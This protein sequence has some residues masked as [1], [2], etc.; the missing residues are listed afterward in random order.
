MF[1]F[2]LPPSLS[3]PDLVAPCFCFCFVFP[4]SISQPL[5][6]GFQTHPCTS[7]DLLILNPV[8]TTSALSLKD[9][10][11]WQISRTHLLCA[12]HSA[13]FWGTCVLGTVLCSYKPV[14]P[15]LEASLVP[16]SLPSVF[17]Q[18]PD[19]CLFYT[20]LLR[21]VQQL[22]LSLTLIMF[23]SHTFSTSVFKSP[24]KCEFD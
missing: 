9:P 12:R 24:V 23:P 20:C 6:P 18:S 16:P 3:P 21:L 5:Q 17:N 1:T 10:L 7:S 15:T 2:S 13:M 14:A 8:G 19:P 11:C 22:P 4:P